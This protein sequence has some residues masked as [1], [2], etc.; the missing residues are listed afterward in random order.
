M[1]QYRL[2]SFFLVLFASLPVKALPEWRII[3]QEAPTLKWRLIDEPA[4]LEPARIAEPDNTFD[5]FKVTLKDADYQQEPRFSPFLNTSLQLD[6]GDIRFDAFTISAFNS[7]TY[8]SL[9]TGNQNY[10][11]YIDTGLT[12]KVQLS[13]FYSQADDPL[14][15]SIQG[16][17]KQPSNFWESYG[18]SFKIRTFSA[19]SISNSLFLSLEGWNVGSGGCDAFSCKDDT[20]YSPN[21]FNN[22]Q[23]R[24]F[25]KNLVGSISAPFTWS[26]LDTLQVTFSPGVNLLPSNQGSGQGGSGQFYGTTYY[27]ASGLR[28]YVIPNLSLTSSVSF[29]FGP[30]YNSFNS[31]LKYLRTPVFNVNTQ[32]YI[33]PRISLTLGLTNAFG[34]SPAT[35]L[36]TIPS[37]NQLLYIASFAYVPTDSD[38]PKLFHTDFLSN[39]SLGG[40]TVR[41][42]L[43]PSSGTTETWFNADSAGNLFGYVGHSLSNSFQIDLFSGGV[44][45]GVQ[46]DTIFNRAYLTDNG[47]NWR[48]GG[49]AIPFSNL[50]GSTPYWIGGR[51]SLGRN[52]DASSYQGLVLVSFFSHYSYLAFF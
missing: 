38:S 11:G 37:S 30:G 12:D 51:V 18:T 14:Y 3:K 10:A 17:L 49:T 34:A 52:N 42:A 16:K 50:N 28:G 43:V 25:T 45:S 23:Q 6:Q 22:S 26:A 35:S 7:G 48:V 41:P 46:Q 15:T 1:K 40:I 9:G 21:I 31:E 32:W 19:E 13:I 36:L 29:P 44:F 27:L 4:N 20:S 39:A 47:W 33:D 24:V 8:T 2:F 5:N